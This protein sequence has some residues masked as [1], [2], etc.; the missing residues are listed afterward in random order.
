MR[1][2]RSGWD[3]TG[4]GSHPFAF[5]SFIVTCLASK[6]RR[7]YISGVEHIEIGGGNTTGP[8]CQHISPI[9]WMG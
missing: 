2:V 5:H 8:W 9:G 6:R 3:T 7:L 4:Y 1:I